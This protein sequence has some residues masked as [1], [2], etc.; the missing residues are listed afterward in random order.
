MTKRLKPSEPEVDAGPHDVFVERGARGESVHG[1]PAERSEGSHRHR[2]R[3]EVDLEVLR[4]QGPV[5]RQHPFH[6]AARCET[7]SDRR[8]TADRAGV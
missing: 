5:R 6:A 2:L 7:R 8:R 1:E 3:T 4:L